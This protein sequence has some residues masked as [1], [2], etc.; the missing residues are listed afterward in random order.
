MGYFT[1]SKDRLTSC[2]VRHQVNIW[3]PRLERSQR[4]C[5]RVL[6]YLTLLE[7]SDLKGAKSRSLWVVGIGHLR[8]SL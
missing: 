5:P 7:P 3:D 4:P 1:G 8:S 6:S 2:I